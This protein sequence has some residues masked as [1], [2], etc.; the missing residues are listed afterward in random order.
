MH[1]PAVDFLQ[2]ADQSL[3]HSWGAWPLHALP[4]VLGLPDVA[5]SI[6]DGEDVGTH[7][8]ALEAQH[9]EVDGPHLLGP[10]PGQGSTR[11]LNTA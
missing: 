2:H 9:N 8:V 4:K 1:R 6:N 5:E 7:L 10:L 11:H 3:Q